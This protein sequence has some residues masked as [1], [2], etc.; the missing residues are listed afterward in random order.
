MGI[1][2]VTSDGVGGIGA[3]Q[4][5]LA[6]GDGAVMDVRAVVD[7]SAVV[8][9]S[10]V[11]GTDAASWARHIGGGGTGHVASYGTK[12]EKVSRT[13]SGGALPFTAAVSSDSGSKG[14]AMR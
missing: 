8:G 14:A 7:M 2:V 3:G 6:M 13:R 9:D 5:V 10:A 1:S 12:M 11:V 4:V